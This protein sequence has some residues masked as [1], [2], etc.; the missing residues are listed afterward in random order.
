MGKH[1]IPFWAIS[2]LGNK[3]KKYKYPNSK[4][5]NFLFSFFPSTLLFSPPPPSQNNNVCR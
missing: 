3:I 2:P 5:V 1:V 4:T